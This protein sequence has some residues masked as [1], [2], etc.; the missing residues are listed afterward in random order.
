M[1]TIA[2]HAAA[3]RIGRKH[4]PARNP[5][6]R[7]AP[8][9]ARS[10]E[11]NRRPATAIFSTTA[12]ARSRCG[13]N[14]RTRRMAGTLASAHP[15]L[16]RPLIMPRAGRPPPCAVPRRAGRAIEVSGGGA[17]PRSRTIAPC[18]ALSPPP[19]DSA[20][21]STLPARRRTRRAGPLSPR[22]AG[23]ACRTAATADGVHMVPLSLCPTPALAC[24]TTRSVHLDRPPLP[25]RPV[26]YAGGP[27]P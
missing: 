15:P 2:R 14:R 27:A 16:S 20:R 23:A 21:R 8:G 1:G 11:A 17:W 25:P 4:V 7:P 6:G 10:R 5:G 18:T 3:V 12:P 9:K 19:Q 22:A 26:P 13:G 24:R